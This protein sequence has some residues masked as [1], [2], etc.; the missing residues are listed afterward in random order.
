MRVLDPAI[1]DASLTTALLDELKGKGIAVSELVGFDTSP[2]AV[3]EA[4]ARISPLS[5]AANISVG[6]FLSSQESR[7]DSPTL[8]EPARRDG[9][10]VLIA[11]PPYV[12]TQ[13]LGAAESQRIAARFGLSGRVDLYFAFIIAMA[14]ALRPGGIAGIIVSNRFMTTRSGAPIRQFL[15]ETFDLLSVY[16]LGDTRLFEAAVLPAVLLLRK[17]DSSTQNQTT[18]F[19]TV[20]SA[21][22]VATDTIVDDVISALKKPGTVRILSGDVYE[23]RRGTLAGDADLRGIWRLGSSEND[24]WLHTVSNNTAKTFG[25][26]GRIRV[27]IKTTADKVFIRNDWDSFSENERPETLRPLI[28]HRIAQRFTARAETTGVRVLYTHCSDGGRRRAI[29]LT[30]F[31]R[32]AR[33]LE[34]HRATLEARH[35]VIEAGRN[36]YE[37]WVPHDP[38]LWSAPK[39]VFRDITARPEFWMDRSGAV[40][41]G[42]CYWLAGAPLDSLYL[43]LA[44][45]NSSFIESFY[46]R[47]F[48]N[49]LYAGRRRFITQYVEHFP[50]PNESSPVGRELIVLAKARCDSTDLT[51]QN[52]L[53]AQ[54]DSAVWRA[55]GLIREESARERYL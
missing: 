54:I 55:F 53:E 9:F 44:V 11:N 12:R 46:D 39:L 41:N 3:S 38:D 22:D 27:G 20:Y 52:A 2:N 35:Y 17:R 23:I 30:R 47:R 13:V 37:I 43:A 28:T 31:P 14:N 42:D 19:T 4:R 40:V 16:D 8:F 25:D 1:G 29:D 50:L 36:W 49:K 18:D 24:A 6:D 45:A 32:S 7:G 48:H 15:R 21:P 26:L 10:D 5:V 33:Y 51:Q 34:Q